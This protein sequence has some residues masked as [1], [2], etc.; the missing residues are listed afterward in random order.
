MKEQNVKKRVFE[1]IQIGNGADIYSRLFDIF[2]TVVIF[3]NLTVTVVS[4]FDEFTS[5]QEPIYIIELATII[6]FLVE[7]VL[8]LW[9]AEYLYSGKKK[10]QAVLK[11]IFS[12]YGIVDILTIVPFFLPLIF[13]AGAVAFR[14]LR[15]IRIFRLF[16]INVKYDAF[17]VIVDVLNEKKSQ[18]FSSVC[19]I[20]ILMVASS[21]CMYSIE[22]EAQ[23]EQFNNA[24][25]G[26]WWSMST[27]LTVGYGDIYP[28]TVAGKLMAIIIAFL[29]VGMVA[30]PTG[31]ISAGFVEQFAKIKK[32]AEFGEENIV[33]L[34]TSHIDD[35]HPWVGKKIKDVILPPALLLVIIKRGKEEIVP[36]GDTVFQ[37]GDALIFGAV[38][39]E[40][41]REI[42]LREI[43]IKGSHPWV[44]CQIKDIDISR[45]EIVVAIVRNGKKIIPNGQTYIKNGDKV[46]LYSKHF[47][48]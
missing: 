44:N 3:L 20:L 40:Y 27:L 26:I 43:N 19:L 37:K 9:T 8:R 12:I 29:G 42:E 23:P 46:I 6:I 22:H 17:N 21:L 41:E 48:R 5:F 1:I 33:D 34:I 15:V 25:S 11:Y 10:W 39:Y 32:N 18:I 36:N 7:Y 45:L 31:I 28:I 35:N 24:F 30:I 16:R 38:G 47:R 13:P 2:I 4:T 14:V